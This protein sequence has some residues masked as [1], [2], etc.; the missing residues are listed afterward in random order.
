M[1]NRFYRLKKFNNYC[2]RAAGPRG[3]VTVSNANQICEHFFSKTAL[4]IFPKLGTH[5]QHDKT[6]KRTR[7]FVREKSGSFNNH[8]LVFLNDPISYRPIA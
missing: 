4:R 7:P 6:K 1:F 2:R 5:D 3:Q 8:K